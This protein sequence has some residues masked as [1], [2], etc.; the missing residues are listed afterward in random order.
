[1]LDE[2]RDV[3]AVSERMVRVNG[4]RHC[5]PPICLCNLAE[6]DPRSGILMNRVHGVREGREIEPGKH[7]KADHVLRRVAFQIVPLPNTLHFKRGLAHKMIQ[8][9]MKGMVCEP[10]GSVWP[11]HYAGAVNLP[12]QPE[13]AID[14][15]GAEVLNQLR[16]GKGAM[17]EGEKYR[18]AMVL[19]VAMRC[20]AIDAKADAVVGLRVDPKEVEDSRARPC[21]RIYLLPVV[22]KR[23]V[24]RIM[25]RSN[26]GR[27]SNRMNW[28]CESRGLPAE[29]DWPH[30]ERNVA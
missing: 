27:H 17:N 29:R 26:F 24:H 18:K 2:L 15:A 25:I 4:D 23:I 11:V 20:S 6:G 22:V 21:V 5:A 9:R 14:D 19:R 30:R 1:M 13:F 16:G 3:Q 8:T 10:D 28:C 12:V 7:R